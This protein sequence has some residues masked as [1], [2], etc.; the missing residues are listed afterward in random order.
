[1]QSGIDV[2]AAHASLKS[3]ESEYYAVGVSNQIVGSDWYAHYKFFAQMQ[4]DWIDEQKRFTWRDKVPLSF[5][6]W[7]ILLII[8]GA[9]WAAWALFF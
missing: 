3:I 7:I 4:H 6:A 9:G 1:M 2:T 8:G 5:R